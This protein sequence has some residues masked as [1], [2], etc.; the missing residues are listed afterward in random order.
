MPAPLWNDRANQQALAALK[1]LPEE[2][3]DPQVAPFVRLAWEALER[4]YSEVRPNLRPLLEK[5]LSELYLLSK[6]DPAELVASLGSPPNL[7]GKEPLDAAWA[8]LL[9]LHE[10]MSQGNLYPPPGS[11]S[12]ASLG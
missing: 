7:A 1:R 3:P 2:N 9:H 12:L 8:A 5:R 10:Q 11:S 4:M 6:E